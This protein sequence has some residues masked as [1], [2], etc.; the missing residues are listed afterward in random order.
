[1]PGACTPSSLV[2]RMWSVASS[3]SEEVF[4]PEHAAATSTHARIARAHRYDRRRM[5]A[6]S[7]AAP[8]TLSDLH[9][10]PVTA[11]KGIGPK[12]ADGLEE[13][14][15]TTVLDLLTYYPRRWVDRTNEARVGDLRDGE[16]ALVLVTVRSTHKTTT[17]TRKQMVTV[18]TGDESGGS[19]S[20]SSTRRGGSDSSTPGLQVALFGRAESYRG[21]LTM[22]NPVVDLIGDRTGRIVPVYPQSEKARPHDVGDRG[23]GRDG[24]ARGAAPGASPIRFPTRCCSGCAW[25]AGSRRSGRS[26]HPNRWMRRR[27]ARRRLVFDELLRVQLALVLRKRAIEQEAVGISH[28]GRRRARSRASTTRLPFPLTGAQRTGHRAD[29]ARPRRPSADA[30]PPPGR[31]R[32]GQDGRRDLGAAGRRAR[33]TPRRARWRRPRCSRSST[34]SASRAARRPRGARPGARSPAIVRCASSCS[35]TAPPRP[36]GVASRRGSST[37]RSTSSSARTRSSRKGCELR[38][39]G[40]VVIDEQ[41]R[42]GVE[43]RAMLRA[44]GR[45]GA[46]ARRARDDGDPD[47]A[48]RGDDR[49]RRP[50]RE[51]PRRDAS[52][53]HADR[54]EV[55]ARRG[56]DERGVGRR[57][58]RGRGRASG[59]RRVPAHR[60]VG[61]ARGGVRDRDIRAAAGR[62]ARRA[63]G[64]RC[65]TDASPR[66]RRR[67]SSRRSARARSTCSSRRR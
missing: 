41:H 4:E 36:S 33:R 1:M 44:K 49:V 46:G 51:R 54:D 47:P 38:S 34:R 53:S 14:G 19:G 24:A 62:R 32:R 12:K 3:V 11:L 58:R 57:A 16:E 63:C 64:S 48:H 60:R 55:G 5:T 45:D 27:S 59:V 29:R 39:L 20:C 15:V 21:R 25:R 7:A 30:P 8:L 18:E 43:Q 35:R 40:V 52:G 67:R 37:G 42:F 61:E 2:T 65:C 50:R 23:L 10:I 17:R 31:R 28:V 26:T 56:R 22:T 9:A 13:L 6:P 66:P